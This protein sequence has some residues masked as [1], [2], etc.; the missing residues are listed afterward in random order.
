MTFL[1]KHSEKIRNIS[2]WTIFIF[3]CLTLSLK[4]VEVSAHESAKLIVNNPDIA[5]HSS[6]VNS[7]YLP[8]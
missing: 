3:A 6:L 4:M 5:Q 2:H 7:N 8:F 1:K